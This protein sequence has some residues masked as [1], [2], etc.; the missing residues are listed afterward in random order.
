MSQIVS[1]ILRVLA[2]EAVLM[3]ERDKWRDEYHRV[4]AL[5]KTTEQARAIAVVRYEAAE[6]ALADVRDDLPANGQAPK[7]MARSSR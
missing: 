1:H 2:H 7:P 3:R 4:E 5:W 6:T